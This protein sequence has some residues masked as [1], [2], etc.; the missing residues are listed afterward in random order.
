MEALEVL[1]QISMIFAFITSWISLVRSNALVSIFA[2]GYSKKSLLFPFV[3]IFLLCY[4]VMIVIQMTEFSYGKDRAS[5]IR[6]HGAVGSVTHDIFFQYNDK[7]VYM[8]RLYPLQQRAQ[9]L[10]IFSVSGETFGVI[11]AKEA[12]FENN[13]WLMPEVEHVMLEDTKVVTKTEQNYISLHGFKPRVLETVYES[14]V[15]FTIIDAFA[16]IDILFDQGVNTDRV[17]AVI[18]HKLLTP[19]F[20]LI[21]I[22]IYF[23]KLP[24]HARFGNLAVVT[25]IFTTLS[26]FIWGVIFALYRLTSTSTITPEIGMVMPLVVLLTYM[27]YLLKKKDRLR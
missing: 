11:Y 19:F 16:A 14:G 8:K 15:G 26:L 12:F 18:F 4:A 7:H 17:R 2:F 1:W 3:A 5:Q 13:Q 24:I 22:V 25:T 21:L 9:E 23:Y 27:M 6:S 20:V 10:R